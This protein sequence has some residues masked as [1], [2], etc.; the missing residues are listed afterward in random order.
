MTGQKLNKNKTAIGE[1]TKDEA[2]P[3]DDKKTERLVEPENN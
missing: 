2:K 3:R 1:I